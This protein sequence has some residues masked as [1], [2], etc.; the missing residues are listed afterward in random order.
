MIFNDILQAS[1]NSTFACRI[2]FRTRF[3]DTNNWMCRI[4]AHFCFRSIFNCIPLGPT[5]PGEEI[6]AA[7]FSGQQS[8]PVYGVELFCFVHCP[9]R[10]QQRVKPAVERR[11]RRRRIRE[12]TAFFFFPRVY[13][14]GYGCRLRSVFLFYFFFFVVQSLTTFHPNSRFFSS[15]SLLFFLILCFLIRCYFFLHAGFYVHLYALRATS[16]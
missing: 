15:L 10:T 7:N 8:S 2:Q 5:T 12:A 16:R 14:G 3:Q 11:I 9:S 4:V 1:P 13:T 6:Q